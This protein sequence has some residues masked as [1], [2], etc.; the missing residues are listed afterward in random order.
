[1][2]GFLRFLPILIP[3]WAVCIAIPI[4]LEYDKRAARKWRASQPLAQILSR[5]GVPMQNINVAMVIMTDAIQR[6]SDPM[7]SLEEAFQKQGKDSE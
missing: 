4:A 2:D 3:L 7:R 1:M 5:L 6:L